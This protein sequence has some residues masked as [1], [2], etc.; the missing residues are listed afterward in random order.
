MS[1]RDEREGK[2]LLGFVTCGDD[3]KVRFWTTN[4]AE[5]R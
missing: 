3:T 4:V 2:E 1:K 5:A